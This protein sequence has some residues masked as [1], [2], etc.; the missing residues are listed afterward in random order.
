M[1]VIHRRNRYS[2]VAQ[3]LSM[4]CVTILG[5]AARGNWIGGHETCAA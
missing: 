2:V 4:D 3:R 1:K 5:V